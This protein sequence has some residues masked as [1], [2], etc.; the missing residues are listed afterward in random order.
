MLVRRQEGS[1]MRIGYGRTSTVSQVAGLEAQ[2]RDL[3]AAGCEK[4][5]VEQLTS[6]ASHRPQLEAAIAFAR[7]GDVFTVAKLDRL[8]RSVFDLLAIVKRLEAK[9]VTLQVL[10]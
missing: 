4:V 1:V 8:A 3:A 6:V 2:E 5:F 10:D 7:E 9:G